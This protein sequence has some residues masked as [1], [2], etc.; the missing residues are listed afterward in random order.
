MTNWRDKYQP[1]SFRGVAFKTVSHDASGGRRGAVHEYPQRDV[2]YFEDLGRRAKTYDIECVVLGAE[3]MA[4]RD[5]LI[6]ALDAYGPGIL[7]HPYHGQIEV[8]V[9]NYSYSESTEEG[10]LARFSIQFVEAGRAQVGDAKADTAIAVKASADTAIKTA[11]NDFTN[12]YNMDGMPGYIDDAMGDVLRIFGVSA[13]DA[14]SLIG[15][16]GKALNAY[17]A[18]IE[19]LDRGVSLIRTPIVLAQTVRGII[20]SVAAMAITPILRLNALL[21]IFRSP[22]G[23]RDVIGQ[24]P[25]RNQQRDNVTA[26]AQLIQQIAAAEAVRA[27]SD[28]R[29]SSY[30]EAAAVRENVAAIIDA[31]ALVAADS[32]SDAHQEALDMLRR[33]M[34]RDVT[35]RGAS[36]ARLFIYTPAQS[37]PALV[38]AN[39][40]YGTAALES[41]SDDLISRNNIVHPGFVSGGVPLELL[42]PTIGTVIGASV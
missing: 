15:G 38:I 34:V 4:G 12:A 35:T 22:Q 5:A 2:P 1:G 23:F 39:R 20:Q 36:L 6:A 16:A 31:A 30:E 18:G 11:E 41:R 32:G 14:A 40:I 28:I 10:G 21:A 29:F 17:Q 24:T 7:L 8:S 13:G 9:P 27:V 37:E 25:V 19:L 33:N 3:Y 42:T 26:I